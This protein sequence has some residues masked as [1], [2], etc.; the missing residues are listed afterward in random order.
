MRCLEAAA[1]KK[2]QQDER[3]QRVFRSSYQTRA[4]VMPWRNRLARAKFDGEGQRK[5]SQTSP[6]KAQDADS[7]INHSAL[8]QSKERKQAAFRSPLW[9]NR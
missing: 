1:E 2:D 9:L 6:S 8:A 3:F 5:L 4:K 7:T